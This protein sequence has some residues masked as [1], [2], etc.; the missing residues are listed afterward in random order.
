MAFV[1]GVLV[2]FL[3][4]ASFLTTQQILNNVLVVGGQHINAH[5]TT[6]QAINAVYSPADTAINIWL[7]KVN[8]SFFFQE[9]FQDVVSAR[10]IAAT[11]SIDIWG[12]FTVFSSDSFII[13]SLRTVWLTNHND[14]YIDS[15]AL[16]RGITRTAKDATL[17]MG[18]GTNL[19]AGNTFTVGH[20]YIVN[21]TVSFD[22]R[23]QFEFWVATS[24]GAG[25]GYLY[26]V[27][28]YSHY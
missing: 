7:E 11:A 10:G 1:L 28:A 5:L 14:V 24:G 18:D 16:Y 26:T 21:Q 25:S 17:I 6:Q 13:D 27:K 3:V 2:V 9:L 8:A 23:L 22:W 4:G 20:T 15:V 12:G 19:G